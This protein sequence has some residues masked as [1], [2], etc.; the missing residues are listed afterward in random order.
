V[1][2]IREFVLVE[3]FV[4]LNLLG[5]L[6]TKKFYESTHMGN[7]RVRI[8]FVGGVHGVGKSTCCQ[9]AS[10]RCDVQWVTASALIKNERES[11]VIQGSKEV[12]DPTG[13]QELLISAIRKIADSGHKRILLDGHFTLLKS[14]GEIVAI[15]ANV[16]LRLGLE[17]IIVFKDEPESIC[18]R[19]RNRD[20]HSRTIS[21]VRGHQDAEIA[22]GRRVAAALG[23][24]FLTLDAFDADGLVGA[25]AAP[26]ILEGQGESK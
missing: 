7:S 4:R 11:A 15:E 14:G 12:S 23:I 26:K 9:Q 13:N 5:F 22:Q 2:L 3:G 6:L 16:F 17:M 18:K 1:V 19:L 24:Q 8:I 20:G 25:I 21:M 10:E